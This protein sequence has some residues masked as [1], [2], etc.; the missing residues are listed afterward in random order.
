MK[1]IREALSYDDV[2]LQPQFGV[3]ETRSKADLR[4]ILID[5]WLLDMPIVSAP[6]SSVTETS[7]A[8]EMNRLGGLGIIHRFTSARLWMVQE[9]KCNLGVAVG[10]NDPIDFYYDVLS[11]KGTDQKVAF[12]LDVA[13]A[14]SLAVMK[15]CLDLKTDISEITLIVGNI[16]TGQ[17]AA[18][19]ESVGVDA[20]KVGIGPGAACT[21]RTVTG[22]G[23]PQLTAIMDVREGT[24]LPIIADGGIKNSGDIVKAIAA[25][26]NTVMLGKLLAGADES[27]SPGKYWGMASAK[28]NGHKAPEGIEGTVPKTGPVEDTI[29]SLLWG[30][31]S[32]VSYA[33]FASLISFAGNGTFLKVSPLAA[34]ETSTRLD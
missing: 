31:R 16:A 21:T 28:E 19:L 24:N 6:M 18:Q 3:L 8:V 32:G 7:M 9:A 13:H 2:L 27:P 23:V 22:F 14:D 5:Y 12:V 4:S 15:Y 29:K 30:V 34:L 10:L 26:A 1:V 17:A 20:V 25:G 33:G 11:A